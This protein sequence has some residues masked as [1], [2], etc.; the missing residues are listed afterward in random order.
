MPTPRQYQ[1]DVDT[2]RY[3]NRVNT[4]RSLNGL[5][6]IQKSDA[7]DIDNFVIG[8]KDLGIWNYFVCWPLRSIHNIGS[9]SIVL[10]LGGQG[11]KDG[12]L[13]NSPVWAP[14]GLNT[15]DGLSQRVT[16][17]IT[18]EENKNNSLI[19]V[20][21]LTS[22][23]S[24]GRRIFGNPS[25]LN[26][27]PLY[28]LVNANT[29]DSYRN[30]KFIGSPYVS[31]NVSAVVGYGSAGN[32]IPLNTYNFYASSLNTDTTTNNWLACR[33]AQIGTANW[34]NP[35]ASY[36]LSILAGQIAA[37]YWTGTASFAAFYNNT[38]TTEQ[39]QSLRA[40]IKSSIGKGLNL[41]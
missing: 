14:E 29:T 1:F 39:I 36:S 27:T 32:A 8:L 28:V 5:A 11:N 34:S 25:G 6:D 15:T 21:S 26:T 37:D 17:P 40:L 16:T 9:G 24:T 20:G 38:L 7:V 2:K 23:S 31:V 3:L 18:Y 12:T 4:Y 19:F 33:N 35:P 22:T 30:S 13:V 10:S 41:P